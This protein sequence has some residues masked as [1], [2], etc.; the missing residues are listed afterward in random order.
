M[1]IYQSSRRVP[2]GFFATSPL[3]RWLLNDAASPYANIGTAA[4]GLTIANAGSAG[5]G[6]VTAAQRALFDKGVLFKSGAS[7]DRPVIYTGNPASG[8]VVSG[9]SLTVMCW[10]QYSQIVASTPCL[11]KT[12]DSTLANY[13][14]TTGTAWELG[15]LGGPNYGFAVVTGTQ[16]SGTRTSL[17]GNTLSTGQQCQW[18]HLAGTYDGAT[19]KMLVNGQ[20][21]NSAAKTGSLDPG[22][23]NSNQGGPYCFGGKASTNVAAA[24]SSAACLLEDAMVFAAVIAEDA[25]REY[26]LRTQGQFRG[27]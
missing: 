9:T 21:L 7:T 22:T 14:N 1:P 5:T 12:Y 8:D 23:G 2:N 27:T 17:G 18:V 16:G 4:S 3:H 26:V 11:N 15:I 6:S 24:S 19:M 13:G 20:V 25:V 10:V